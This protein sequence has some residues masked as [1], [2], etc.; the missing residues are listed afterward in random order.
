VVV[1]ALFPR[2][3]AWPIAILAAWLGIAWGFKGW[4]LWR[5][6]HHA[7]RGAHLHDVVPRS[8]ADDGH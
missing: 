3:L 5:G 6:A 4:T 1:A 8:E 2:L 7:G